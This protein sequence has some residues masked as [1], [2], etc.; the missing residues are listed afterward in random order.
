MNELNLARKPVVIGPFAKLSV[1]QRRKALPKWKKW[2]PRWIR[3]DEENYRLGLSYLTSK[4]KRRKAKK[5][6]KEAKK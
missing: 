3:K 5:E 1:S 6:E 4:E 2:F